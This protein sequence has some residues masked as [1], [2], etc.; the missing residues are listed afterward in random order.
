ML[1][2]AE[3]A[4]YRTLGPEERYRIF[5]ELA[6]WA[7]QCLDADGEEIGRRRWDLIRRQHDE[8]NRRLE[9]AFRRLP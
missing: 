8:G 6:A 2:A 1:S 3:I 5:L 9:E 4:R 7:W